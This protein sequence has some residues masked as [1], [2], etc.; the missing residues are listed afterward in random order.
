MQATNV[1]PASEI[2]I[3]SDD[4]LANPV[5]QALAEAPSAFVE[6]CIGGARYLP[7]FAPFGAT[8]DY[9]PQQI[10][11]LA[12]M[13]LPGQR[14]ALVTPNKQQLPSDLELVREAIVYQMVCTNRINRS[15]DTRIEQLGH[16]DVA[17]MIRLAEMTEPGPFNLRT[18]EL[19]HFFG[20]KEGDP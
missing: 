11:Q 5:W 16:D 14:L 13:L 19:G 17:A 9:T 8:P 3:A 12:D 15:S 2:E 18:N 10:S 20:I 4:H 7:E 6:R 1:N